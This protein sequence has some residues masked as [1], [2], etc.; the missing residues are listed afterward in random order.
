MDFVT[1]LPQSEDWRGNHY[2]S[3]LVI[4]NRLTKMVYYEPVQTTITAPVLRKV[5]F[6]VVVEYYSLSNSI[7]SDCSSVFTSKFWFSLCYFLTIKQ[8][9]CTA[10]YPQ[11]DGRTKWQNNT[12]EAYLRAFINYKQD[13]WARLLLVAEFAYNNAKYAS[14]GYTPFKLNYG[15][16]LRVSYK[17]TLTPVPG[18]KQL[19]S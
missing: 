10:F 4:I 6:N 2:Y 12:I 7:I 18:S 1:G 13:N 8:R 14:T 15:Y 17:K 3:I 5:I 16:H 11:T 9:L 19:M